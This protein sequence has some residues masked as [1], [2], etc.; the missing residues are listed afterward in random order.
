[1]TRK[2]TIL[3]PT[4]VG[5][6]TIDINGEV[7]TAEWNG[8]LRTWSPTG[9]PIAA[10]QKAKDAVSAAAFSPNAVNL[11]TLEMTEKSNQ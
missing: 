9:V 2:Q 10:M 1:L 11:A 6:A 4:A 3:C 8:M 7:L 5:A